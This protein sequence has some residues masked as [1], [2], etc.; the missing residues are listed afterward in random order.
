MSACLGLFNGT[1]LITRG[2]RAAPPP[3][4][5]GPSLSLSPQ[6]RALPARRSISI[7]Q[8]PWMDGS[9]NSWRWRLRVVLLRHKRCV[10]VLVLAASASCG[11]K[12][13]GYVTQYQ[14]SSTVRVP[15]YYENYAAPAKTTRKQAPSP[16]TLSSCSVCVCM[17]V[18]VH[19]TREL[20][21]KLLGSPGLGGDRARDDGK[22]RRC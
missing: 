14:C 12:C 18:C 7:F 2:L 17:C 16:P 20:L 10:L 9:C 8:S 3:S 15:Y 6:R 22:R 4:R 5:P 19:P 21:R 1:G 13:A 11:E